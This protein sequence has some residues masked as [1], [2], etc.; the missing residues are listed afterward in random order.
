MR[1]VPYEF[2]ERVICL[3]YLGTRGGGSA[4]F[5][6]LLYLYSSRDSKFKPVAITSL[7]NED[8]GLI[9]SFQ[10][11][12]SIQKVSKFSIINLVT[13][14]KFSRNAYNFCRL[15]RVEKLLIVMPHP[16][17]L[18]FYSRKF[19]SI[20]EVISIVHDNKRHRGDLWP[21]RIDLLLRVW[22]SSKQ[23]FLSD[24]VASGF[25]KWIRSEKSLVF[26]LFS[27]CDLQYSTNLRKQG[28]LFVGRGRKYQRQ[29]LE[30]IVEQLLAKDISVCLAGRGY[31]KVRRFKA[32]KSANLT[33]IDHWL[34]REEFLTLIAK[35]K[36][37]L[38][39][40]SEASQSGIIP[41]ARRLQTL[42]VCTPVGG[43]IEQFENG[44]EGVVSVSTSRNDVINATLEALKKEI[45]D[46]NAASDDSR[47]WMLL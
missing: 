43:L 12:L 27:Q 34:T 9:K 4:L 36:V 31:K 41:V 5:R 20:L 47:Q 7:K 29:D 30:E 17:D 18:I 42:V 24:Y 44:V 14:L 8:L 38:L 13:V 40:Y 2:M 19:K 32:I 16:L 15:N 21:T 6:D 35:A 33:L 37:V 28:V 1:G 23:I 22:L 39:P 3:V 25:G 10:I 11:P 46:Y 26:P 45:P